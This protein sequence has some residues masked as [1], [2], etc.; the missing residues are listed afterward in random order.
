MLRVVLGR[1][2]PDTAWS[3]PGDGHITGLS[4]YSRHPDLDEAQIAT[5]QSQNDMASERPQQR[6]IHPNTHESREDLE[7][8]GE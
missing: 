8:G 1:A 5:S 4:F 7:V 6:T 3:G 2:R